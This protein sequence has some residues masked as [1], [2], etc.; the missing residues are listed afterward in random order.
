MRYIALATDYDG[1]LAA[2]GLVAR[3]VLKSL[4][5]LRSSGRKLILVTGR[6]IRHVKEVFPEY[7]LFDSVVAENGAV[8]FNPRTEEAQLLCE[9][10]SQKLIDELV[11]RGV[12]T[13][14]V[15]QAIV[16]T[17]TPH[18]QT[19]LSTIRDLGLELEIIFNKGAVMILPTG[20]NKGTGLKVALSGLGL[21][22][23]NVVGLGDAEN[24][25]AFLQ[26]CECS[27]AV[28][29][30]LPAVKERTDGL[31]QAAR[32]H[33]VAEV[34][35]RLVANDLI[36]HSPA[37]HLISIG[38]HEDKPVV[39]DPYDTGILICGISGGGKSKATLAILERL[40]KVGYQF[41]LIDPEG[42]YEGFSNAIV[43]GDSGRAPTIDEVLAILA[44]PDRSAIVNLLDMRLEDR[45][46][47]FTQLLPRIQ[48]MRTQFGRPH[49]LVI[50]EAHHL[51]PQ[52]WQKMTRLVPEDLRALLMITVHPERIAAEIFPSVNVLIA[53]GEQVDVTL[54]AF[55]RQAGVRPPVL[56]L[57]NLSL[58]KGEGLLW[59]VDKSAPKLIALDR[60]ETDKVR[61]RRKYAEGRLPDDRSFYFTGADKKMN[62]RA[63]N[64]TLF[65]QMAEG[66]DD[67]TWMYHLRNKHYSKWFAE[68]IKDE[69][70]A[71]EAVK[72]EQDSGLSP[73]ESRRIICT[74]ILDRYTAA[75]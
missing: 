53:V 16:A 64:L 2:N 55:G 5:R 62:L 63:H 19:V 7:E 35:D 32:G 29:N 66:V 43:T 18:E 15:G 74:A 75:A 13:L 52:E 23:H 48:E 57:E 14:S 46:D 41:C 67:D 17:W 25:H 34:I 37:R 33:G 22:P 59:H 65:A 38:T 69:D 36:D 58:A 70:L 6:E 51:F 50:D 4:E 3:E 39:I 26:T 45:P 71:G 44:S 56:D 30:A 42:D 28:S 8:V 73:D 68:M 24:D 31:T 27:F 11:A 40:S 47:F 61:H 72:V 12:D 49:W 60:A 1:T 54:K 9:A 20:V 10:P 21:S